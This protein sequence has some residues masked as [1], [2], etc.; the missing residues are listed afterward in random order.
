MPIEPGATWRR[1]WLVMWCICVAVLAALAFASVAPA[2][3]VTAFI[4][5]FLLPELIALKIKGD[6]YPPLTYVV[7]RYVPRWIPIAVTVG[8]GTWMGAVWWQSAVHPL[9]VVTIIGTFVGW[10]VGHWEV[11]YDELERA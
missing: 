5:L 7:A 3:W 8:I 2:T 9:V 1:S 6:A 10:L 4:V 11:T